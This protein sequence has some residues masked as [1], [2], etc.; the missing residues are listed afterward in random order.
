MHLAWAEMV[1]VRVSC[2]GRATAIG[3]TQ[4]GLLRPSFEDMCPRND[5][6]YRCSYPWRVLGPRIGIRR[7]G[8][9]DNQYFCLP[10]VSK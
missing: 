3:T 4:R 5:H 8:R 2:S 1:A 6:S 7:R 9:D 10:L